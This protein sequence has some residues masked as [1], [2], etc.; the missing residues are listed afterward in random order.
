L[1]RKDLGTHQALVKL[2]QRPLNLYN[3]LAHIGRVRET[4]NSK[5]LGSEGEVE[6]E[7]QRETERDREREREREREEVDTLREKW[8][9][10]SRE[11]ENDFRKI[12]L[13]RKIENDGAIQRD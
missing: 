1:P 8:M 9:G 5:G 13:S 12:E 11:I 7:I 6:R 4:L 2:I 10:Q 3:L